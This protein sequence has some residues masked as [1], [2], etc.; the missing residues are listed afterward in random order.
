MT[1]Y[2]AGPVVVSGASGGLGAATARV[3]A[4]A[5]VPLLLLDRTA[6]AELARSLG[7]EGTTC[8]AVAAEL[9]DADSIARALAEGER[10]LG[11][12]SHLVHCAALLRLAAIR[13]L[14]PAEFRDVLDVNVVGAFLLARAVAVSASARGGSIVLVS[15]VGGIVS[16]ADSV[17]YGASKHAL[18]G[19]M[20]G[21][22][23]AFGPSGVR[24][25]VVCPGTMDTPLF[26]REVAQDW[27]DRLPGATAAKKLESD[28]DESL[29]GEL[30]EPAD[31]ASL[32]AYML[33]RAMR[34]VTGQ[35]Y[36]AWGAPTAL[37]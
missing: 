17:A 13:E 6:P 30:V 25:N 3:L 9:R 4:S 15:S 20:Q 14:D 36:T 26:G 5:G 31:V 8:L 19:V 24:V 27:I 7:A 35:I 28:R 11:P 22:A 21:L 37:G 33:S 10:A 34:A 23:Q 32:C 12:A 16:G 29:L 18:H 1:P 2:P